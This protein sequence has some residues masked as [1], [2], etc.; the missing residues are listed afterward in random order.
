MKLSKDKNE[1][2]CLNGNINGVGINKKHKITDETRFI[3]SGSSITK[4]I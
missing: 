2:G 4:L 1:L 3:L